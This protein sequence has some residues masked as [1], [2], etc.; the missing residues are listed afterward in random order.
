LQ[1]SHTTVSLA[2]RGIE[3]GHLL[4]SA[5]TCP[6]SWNA[7]HLK[8]THPLEPAAQQLISSSD[9]NNRSADF[10]TD[11]R[12]NV[13]WMESITRL[14]AF[15][16]DIGTLPEWP[17]HEQRGSGQSASALVS[18]VSDPAY[19]S[20]VWQWRSQPKNWGGQKIWGGPK[21]MILGE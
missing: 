17:F 10:W 21:C 12:W 2:S 20:G 15:I 8:S 5:F 19:T 6:P 13:K 4:H 1:R 11:H 18:D 14:R 7:R 3:L 16:F 9:G